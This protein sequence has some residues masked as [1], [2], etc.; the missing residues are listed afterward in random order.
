LRQYG[1]EQ[2]VTV[3]VELLAVVMCVGIKYHR[4]FP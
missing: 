4:D 3:D 1:A 2:L